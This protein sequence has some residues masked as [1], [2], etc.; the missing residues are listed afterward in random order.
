MYRGP[1]IYVLAVSLQQ[2]NARGNWNFARS[3]RIRFDLAQGNAGRNKVL[4]WTD[5]IVS[6][7][8]EAEPGS[9]GFGAYPE[10]H[11]EII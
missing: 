2:F 11:Q 7:P 4:G 5:A 1:F 9:A 8:A 3:N 6:D 10:A